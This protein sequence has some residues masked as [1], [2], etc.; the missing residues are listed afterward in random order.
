MTA[1]GTGFLW[2]MVK[3]FYKYLAVSVVPLCECTIH[4]NAYFKYLFIFERA[5]VQACTCE[6]GRGRKTVERESQVGSRLSA[7]SPTWGSI[8][9]P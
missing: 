3:M 1:K 2:G 6:Q 9:Q 8:Y 5:R 4:Q 7:Q